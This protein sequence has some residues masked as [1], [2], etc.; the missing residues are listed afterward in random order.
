MKFVREIPYNLEK[1]KSKLKTENVE[2]NVSLC[3]YL[4]KILSQYLVTLMKIGGAV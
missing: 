1:L 2:Q 3:Q 4:I